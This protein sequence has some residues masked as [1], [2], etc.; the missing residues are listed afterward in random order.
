[1]GLLGEFVQSTQDLRNR[2]ASPGTSAFKNIAGQFA[3]SYV[4]T[5]EDAAYNKNV[6][7]RNS[8]DPGKRKWGAFEIVS[9]A[10][11]FSAD[12]ENIVRFANL[13][14]SAQRALGWGLGLN[15]YLNKDLKIQTAFEETFFDTGG[16][17]V[18]GTQNRPVEN[19]FISRVQVAF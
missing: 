19:A 6:V 11:F 14:S 1:M 17:T 7:P 4:L 3:A 13:S 16:L 9:R 5:G 18:Y 12:K 10:D 8:F 2:G 15:W